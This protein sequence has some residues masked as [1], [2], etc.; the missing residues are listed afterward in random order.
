MFDFFNVISHNIFVVP[1]C[2]A[3]II[4]TCF[5][6]E[7]WG[8]K[9]RFPRLILT[10]KWTVIIFAIFLIS[11]VHRLRGDFVHP[12]F[13]N[14]W[15]KISHH[16]LTIVINITVPFV[17]PCWLMIWIVHIVE[18]LVCIIYHTLKFFLI[19]I[20]YHIVLNLFRV[21]YQIPCFLFLEILHKMVWS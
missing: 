12:L 8:I 15:F 1:W 13:F 4:L 16:F 6:F 7:F 3:K 21:D 17:I 2:C 11:N 14:E 20:F 10:C 18:D 5:V 19:V 9:I